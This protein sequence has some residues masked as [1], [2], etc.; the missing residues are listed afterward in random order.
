MPAK[1]LEHLCVHLPLDQNIE[2]AC[3]VKKLL[4]WH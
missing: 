4:E 3:M 2:A 1:P